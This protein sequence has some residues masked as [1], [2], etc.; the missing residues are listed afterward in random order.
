PR[1]CGSR[2]GPSPLLSVSVSSFV[3]ARL[4][5]SARDRRLFRCLLQGG[6]G[7]AGGVALAAGD[8]DQVG[9]ATFGS[10]VRWRGD[11]LEHEVV[12]LKVVEGEGGG[13]GWLARRCS[14][15]VGVG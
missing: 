1:R 8:V 14:S 13:R 10:A 12:M 11:H 2:R 4:R 9:Y 5:R 6:A 3:A 15:R 7:R